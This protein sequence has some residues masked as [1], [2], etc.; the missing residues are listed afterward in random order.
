MYDPL[1]V[2]KVAAAALVGAL[3][4]SAAAFGGQ[5]PISLKAPTGYRDYCAA[6]PPAQRTRVCGRGGVPTPLWRP[7]H[8]PTVAPGT[9][10]PVSARHAIARKTTG[11][12]DGPIYATHVDPWSVMFPPPQNSLAVGTGWSVDKTPFV[13]KRT[14]TGPFV[15]RGGRIDGPGLLGFSGPG[16]RRPF[17]AFQF[18][19]GRSGAEVAGLTGWPTL[20]WMTAPGCYAVQV[21][22]KSFSRMIVFRVEAAEPE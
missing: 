6:M 8:L 4:A 18:A 1:M 3:V 15:I 10:C 7:L 5:A 2:V 19:A 16:G 11:V 13:R 22:G 14:F 12:G 9:A 21:D 17:E 20:V